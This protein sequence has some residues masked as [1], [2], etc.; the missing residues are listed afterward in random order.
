MGGGGGI[1]GRREVMGAMATGLSMLPL[2]ASALSRTSRPKRFPQGFLWGA[3]SSG[4]QIEG[5]N[6]NSDLW[7]FEHVRPSIYPE[8]SG[9]A[10]NSFKEWRTDLRLAKAL[11]LGAFRF[12]LEW[13]RIEPEPG[14]FSQAMLDHYKAIVD[15][16]H[17]LGLVPVVT[18][19]HFTAPRWFSAKA[20]WLNQDSAS[21]FGR[22]CDRAARALADGLRYVLTLNE[23]NID[24][25]LKWKELLPPPARKI[26]AEMRKAAAK[27]SGSDKFAA[28]TSIAVDELDAFTDGLLAA[29][30][31]GRSAIRAASSS[32]K[33]GFSIAIEDDQAVG[34]AAWRNA[35]RAD[36]YQPWFDVAKGDDFTAIQNYE[37]TVFRGDK[38]LPPPPGAELN[39]RGGEVYPAS[40]VNC[41]RYAHQ[42]TG[43][44]VLITEHGIPTKMDEQRQRFIIDSLN[45]LHDAI[46][47]GVPVLG[48]MHW[49]F[50]ESYELIF[51][52]SIDMG[53]VAVDRKTFRRTPK[54][55]AKLL[56]KI[57]AQNG[58]DP[59]PMI[60][61]D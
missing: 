12:S 59:A 57:A 56:G 61:R 60:V 14:E 25:L 17:T 28:Y 43:K 52:R 9:D 13:S 51:A 23:P 39:Q 58:L 40:L 27:A 2:A 44:P 42:Q 30:K 45:G 20:G 5:N 41:V 10:C 31:T 46:S 16:C 8:S 37:R 54:N 15:E 38:I 19:N 4:H 50:L 3:S 26:Q 1:L 29:H 33:V 6:T 11:G 32:V 49:S 7:L 18:F 35:K 47:D 21:L 55:S 34:D 53:L 36:A 48:Y 24:H 22:Y